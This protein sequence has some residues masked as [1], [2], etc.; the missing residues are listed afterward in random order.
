[1]SASHN[2]PGHNGVKFG[3]SDGGVLPAS[4]AEALAERF[5]S[6]VR[7][8]AARRGRAAR[9]RPRRTERAVSRVFSAC[10]AEKRAAVSAYTLFARAD[11]RGPGGP[12]K[13]RSG[14]WT[15]WPRPARPAPS[16]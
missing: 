16:G 5:R 3:F 6:L 15:T 8:P 14:C 13:T 9:R 2:P 7:D 11:R 10:A 12:R 1:M 4:E